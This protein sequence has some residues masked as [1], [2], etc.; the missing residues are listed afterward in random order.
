MAAIIVEDKGMAIV[1]RFNRPELRSPLSVEVVEQLLMII[2]EVGQR[3]DVERVVF[4][5][6][7]D[8]FASGADLREIALLDGSTAP[9]FALRGQRLMNRISQIAPSTIA[10]VNGICF[11]GA[12]DLALACERRVA[13]HAAVFSHPGSG[14]GII[15]GWGGTQ[16]LPKLVG[17]AIALEMLFTGRRV[18]A[19]EALHLGLVDQIADDPV[20]AALDL[21]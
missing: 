7:G 4:T 12:L 10:A 5:G 17:Q 11:G 3:S 6:V 14:L 21:I 16:R 19:E 15:T 1:I 2:G 18:D 8:V 13:S 20:L 9:G